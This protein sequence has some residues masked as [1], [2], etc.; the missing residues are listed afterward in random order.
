MALPPITSGVSGLNIGM[1]NLKRDAIDIASTVTKGK[2]DPADL[3]KSLVDL[4]QDRSQTEASVKVVQAVD[5]VLGT[6]L[7]V[8]A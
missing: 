7:D 4:N 2:E 5:E 3:A 8:R 6:L 1:E